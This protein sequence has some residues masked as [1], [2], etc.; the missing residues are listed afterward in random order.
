[1]ADWSQ[2]GR[3]RMQF[4]LE[5]W[6][7]WRCM[8]GVCVGLRNRWYIGIPNVTRIAS[9]RT[10][11]HTQIW[12][13][14]TLVTNRLSVRKL[15]N[16]CVRQIW[17]D[18]ES[19]AEIIHLYKILEILPFRHFFF[20]TTTTHSQIMTTVIHTTFLSQTFYGEVRVN[21]PMT[22]N[23]ESFNRRNTTVTNSHNTTHN[24]LGKVS[25]F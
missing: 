15:P 14:S 13:S 17:W 12:C 11:Y 9:C 19:M 21:S 10:A 7:Q 4:S 16:Q 18:S 20:S 8:R 5:E 6:W 3:Q 25:F 2:N 23:N 22:T 24:T 1:M